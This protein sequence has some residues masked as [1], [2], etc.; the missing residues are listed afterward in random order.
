MSIFEEYGASNILNL[1]KTLFIYKIT[2][3]NKYPDHR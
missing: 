1:I 2:G 3:K